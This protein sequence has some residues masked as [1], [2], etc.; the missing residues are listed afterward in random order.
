VA[1]AQARCIAMRTHHREYPM[2]RSLACVS[3][4]TRGPVALIF[5]RMQACKPECHP[6][7]QNSN[8]AM[9]L[10]S[11]CM[12]IHVYIHTDKYTNI[13]ADCRPLPQSQ[14]SLILSEI[15][16]LQPCSAGIDSAQQLYSA[17]IYSVCKM[18][19]TQGLPTFV[20]KLAG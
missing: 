13:H 17:G 10:M 16:A 15:S 7:P 1:T 12:C 20:E 18:L 5:A 11:G 8:S 4:H 9:V 14:T 6:F 2:N 19:H 3:V